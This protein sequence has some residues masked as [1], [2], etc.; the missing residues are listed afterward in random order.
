MD[1]F[2][3]LEEAVPRIQEWR[4]AGQT[5]VFSNGCFDLLHPGHVDYLERARS[6]GDRLVIGLN[7]DDSVRRLKGRDRPINPLADR[8][9]MLVALRAVD[10]VIPFSEDTPL[11]LIRAIRPDFLVKG[12][13]YTPEQVVGAEEV[14]D[15][16]GQVVIQPFLPGYSS[17]D[18][19]RRIRNR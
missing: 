12:G 5:V 16:G 7:D 10:L 3:P 11:A 9:R 19:I 18:L 8:A 4:R 1:R 6:L 17:S 13:D 14:R 15:A 2:L